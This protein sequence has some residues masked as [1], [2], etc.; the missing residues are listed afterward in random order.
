LTAEDYELVRYDPGFKKQILCLQTALWSQDWAVN[1]AYFEW[2]YERNPYLDTPLVYLGLHDGKVVGM[3][4]M[5][6]AHWRVGRNGETIVAP[7]A[8]DS[9]VHAD[10]RQRGLFRRINEFAVQDLAGRYIPYVLN[11]SAGP[12]VYFTSLSMDWRCVGSYEMFRRPAGPGASGGEA[13]RKVRISAKA[14]P[15]R[16]ANLVERLGFD[17]RLQHVKDRTWLAWRFQS[18][19]ARYTFLYLGNKE[20]DGYLVL[21]KRTPKKADRFNI[22]DWEAS[23]D[24]VLLELLEAAIDF[25][26]LDLSV[27][28]ATLPKRVLDCLSALG[29]ERQSPPQQFPAAYLPGPLLRTTDDGKVGE[30]WVAGDRSLSDLANWKLRMVYSDGY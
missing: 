19:L 30:S 28:S 2:K 23:T 1:A 21:Q 22:V 20:L 9:T 4:G 29:F 26:D 24:Q 11:F 13:S 25:A 5:M 14:E 7:C 10:H 6:G 12:V 17:G 18:P 8:G 3:R 15:A 16:M 27:W